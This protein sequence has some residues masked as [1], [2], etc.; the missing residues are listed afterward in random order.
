MTSKSHFRADW[1]QVGVLAVM[2]AG[3]TSPLPCNI[4]GSWDAA[5]VYTYL[6]A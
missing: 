5:P 3:S 4:T 1:A 6:P 2:F